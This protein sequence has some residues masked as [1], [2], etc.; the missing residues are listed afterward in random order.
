MAEHGH[1]QQHQGHHQLAPLLPPAARPQALPTTRKLDFSG[2]QSRLETQLCQGLNQVPLIR[3][4]RG[5]I[6]PGSAG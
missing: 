2:A 5:E 4:R 3:F 1:Q 6:D